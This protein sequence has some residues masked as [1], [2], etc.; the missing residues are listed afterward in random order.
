MSTIA[1]A[2]PRMTFQQRMHRIGMAMFGPANS[3][4]YGPPEPR[5]P[6]RPRDHYGRVILTCGCV[7]LSGGGKVRYHA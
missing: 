2:K 6:V 7:Q 3:G 4:P 5:Q 1:L